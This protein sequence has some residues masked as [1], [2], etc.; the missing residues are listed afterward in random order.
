MKL[1]ARDKAKLDAYRYALAYLRAHGIANAEE[2]LVKPTLSCE[3]Q[4]RPD[5]RYIVEGQRWANAVLDSL[6]RDAAP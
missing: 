6:L 4:A 1:T 3:G 2:L 5:F